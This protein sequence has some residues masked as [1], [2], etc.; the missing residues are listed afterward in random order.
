MGINEHRR[1]SVRKCMF[2]NI[3]GSRTAC[4]PRVFLLVAV[5]L[6]SGAVMEQGVVGRA[7]VTFSPVLSASLDPIKKKEQERS[8]RYRFG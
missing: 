6:C 3:G 4:H 8:A 5:S 2:D 7:L 1:T